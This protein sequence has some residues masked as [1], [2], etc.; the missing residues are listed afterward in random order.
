[1]MA[2]RSQLLVRCERILCVCVCVCVSG[3][4]C[5]WVCVC[6]GGEWVHECVGVWVGSGCVWWGKISSSPTN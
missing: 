5:E 1:M 4:V 2:E 3:G 6:V